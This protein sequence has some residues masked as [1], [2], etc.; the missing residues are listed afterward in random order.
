MKK[1]TKAEIV[2]MSVTLKGAVKAAIWKWRWICQAN[3]KDMINT[4]PKCGLCVYYEYDC[5][6]CPLKSCLEEDDLFCK[7]GTARDLLRCN[8]I[9]LA[10]FRIP[11]KKMLDKIKAIKI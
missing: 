11:A 10:Q 2:K 3:K 5:A 4:W 1:P 9:T 6:D 7:V 8:R